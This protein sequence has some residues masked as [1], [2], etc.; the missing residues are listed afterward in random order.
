MHLGQDSSSGHTNH[1]ENRLPAGE[2]IITDR[3]PRAVFE[4]EKRKDIQPDFLDFSSRRVWIVGVTD[5]T[6]AYDAIEAVL[7]DAQQRSGRKIRVM[8]RDNDRVFLPRNLIR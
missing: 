2:Y 5:R 7:Q 1:R 8:R 6:G 3:P 4:I